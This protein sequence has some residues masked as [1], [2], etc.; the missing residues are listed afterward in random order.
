MKK[1][2]GFRQERSRSDLDWR[3][4]RVSPV[5]PGSESVPS[6]PV[7]S[8]QARGGPLVPAEGRRRR[9]PRGH[10]PM[11]RSARTIGASKT[12]PGSRNGCPG[13]LVARGKLRAPA[14]MPVNLDDDPRTATCSPS[15]SL[16]LGGLAGSSAE[17]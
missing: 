13:V 6:L 7:P 11:H 2:P 16:S 10:D 1:K 5:G 3:T 9:A 14:M 8:S 4:N 12:Y 17:N 15:L